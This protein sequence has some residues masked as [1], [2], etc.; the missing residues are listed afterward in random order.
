M[1]VSVKDNS[2]STNFSSYIVISD[3]QD[4]STENDLLTGGAGSVHVLRIENEDTTN[5]TENF[6]HLY[7]TNSPTVGA[8]G[9]AQ[10][11][12]IKIA[13]TASAG[14]VLTV[15]IKN[16]HAFTNLSAAASTAVDASNNPTG[17]LNLIILG[18]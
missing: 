11:M 4:D 12:K 17:V 16:G 6:V 9:T 7:D 10:E 2:Q 5:G 3:L 1:A 18:S 13:N 8:G 14:K 15:F